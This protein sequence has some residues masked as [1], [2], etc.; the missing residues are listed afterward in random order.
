MKILWICFVWPE[1]DSSAAGTR[2]LELINLLKTSGHEVRTC[3]PCQPNSYQDF[4]IQS[5]IAAEHL[6]AN[7]ERFDSFIA[8]FQPDIV[9]FDRFMI[10]EQFGW[11]VR[12]I[13]PQALR[14]LDTIDL[15]SLRRSRQ[16][17][18]AQL[19]DN[20]VCPELTKSDLQSDDALR[21]ISAIYR[22]DL[23]LVISDFELNL[24][25]LEFNIP[26]SL[27]TLCRFSCQRATVPNSFEKR[28]DFVAIGNFNHAPNLDSFKLLHD[29]LWPR[30]NQLLNQRGILGT[31]LHVFGAYPK[32]DFVSVES[33]ANGFKVMGKTPQASETL[34]KYRVNL[35]PLRFGAGIKGKIADGWASGTP[36]VATSVAAEGMHSGFIFGGSVSDNWDRFVEQAVILYSDSQSWEAAQK[37][38]FRIIDHFFDRSV[39]AQ[40][41]LEA[42]ANAKQHQ[43]ERRIANFTGQMLWHHQ[44][45]STEFFSRWIEV[46]NKLKFT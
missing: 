5:G 12:Q 41:F 27:I 46:K 32:T 26:A 35:A 15:H 31:E 36:C 39:N 40:N 42:V 21:E 14:I 34:S 25:Q 24:L 30:I 43:S 28:A 13:C 17:K 7:D 20:Q 2:T 3:S 4:L 6:P 45:R 8:E 29:F 23:S 33:K 37:N 38:G 18:Q 44:N 1:P 16:R 11:R 19:N 22:C 10:E 9:F